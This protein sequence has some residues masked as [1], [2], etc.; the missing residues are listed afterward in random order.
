MCKKPNSIFY[1]LLA[2]K[3]FWI[4]VIEQQ[5]IIGLDQNELEEIFEEEIEAKNFVL[6]NSAE[7][8]FFYSFVGVQ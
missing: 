2:K 3:E 5:Q 8:D 6:I 4:A 1:G 7:Y